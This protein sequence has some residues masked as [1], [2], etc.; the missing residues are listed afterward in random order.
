VRLILFAEF[1]KIGLFSIGGGL[2]TLP[3]LFELAAK[4]DWLSPKDVG[5][6]LAIA[7]SSPGAVGVNM[8]AQTGFRAG[9]IPGAFIAALGLVTVPIA[10]ILI[11]APMITAF[12]KSSAAAAVLS[13][14]RPAAVGLIAA[15]GFGVWKLAL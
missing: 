4:Y 12:K 11:I 5:D 15:A 2:A 10:V 9:G 13:G 3:F 1:V 14:L 6:F 7:Q 8:A